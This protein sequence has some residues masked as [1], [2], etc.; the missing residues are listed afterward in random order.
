MRA[1]LLAAAVCLIAAA[2]VSAHPS[3]PNVGDSWYKWGEQNSPTFSAA[4]KNVPT[5]KFEEGPCTAEARRSMPAGKTHDH[6]DI[7]QHRFQCNLRQ[8]AFNSLTKELG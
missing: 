5:P 3:A 4:M 7:N 2:T 1:F 6:E 8:T